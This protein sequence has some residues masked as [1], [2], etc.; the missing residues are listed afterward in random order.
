MKCFWNLHL[1]RIVNNISINIWPNFIFFLCFYLK[2]GTWCLGPNFKFVRL[3]FGCFAFHHFFHMAKR[4]IPVNV[5]K[6]LQLSH[7]SKFCRFHNFLGFCRIRYQFLCFLNQYLDLEL[8]P[9]LRF[10][11]F[12]F[13]FWWRKSFD[14]LI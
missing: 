2:E 11:F 10:F 3:D 9:F 1:V 5:E 4:S 12:F 7:Y 13:F 8:E 6:R 14:F